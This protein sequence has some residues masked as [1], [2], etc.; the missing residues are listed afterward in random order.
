MP[1][2]PVLTRRVE[3]TPL[4][5]RPDEDTAE[6]LKVVVPKAQSRPPP[7]SQSEDERSPTKVRR[8]RDVSTLATLAR[9]DPRRPLT[10]SQA[11]ATL[12]EIDEDGYKNCRKKTPLQDLQPQSPVPRKKPRRATR[13]KSDTEGEDG[14]NMADESEA[15]DAVTVLGDESPDLDDIDG[16]ECSS[17]EDPSDDDV[18][19]MLDSGQAADVMDRRMPAPLLEEPGGDPLWRGAT[20]WK[21]L[22]LGHQQR[23][24]PGTPDLAVLIETEDFPTEEA[25]AQFGHP[26]GRIPPDPTVGL[27]FDKGH[28]DPLV[29]RAEEDP[30]FD[31][32]VD[33][34]LFLA[35]DLELRRRRYLDVAP[36]W[37][38]M[39]RDEVEFR[40]LEAAVL[41]DLIAKGCPS[42][43]L[44]EAHA[45]PPRAHND[46]PEPTERKG[47]PPDYGPV[48]QGKIKLLRYMKNSYLNKVNSLRRRTACPGVLSKFDELNDA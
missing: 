25:L 26:K 10:Q 14:G 33:G 48:I 31:A 17:I 29:R 1:E 21:W 7:S 39:R 34:F 6:Q 30:E 41:Q 22:Y 28:S 42:S 23:F 24:L 3:R 4:G 13:P 46:V 15:D 43:G 36:V 27:G 38:P 16:E 8:L 44:R 40:I 47:K 32:Y 9:P 37:D 2:A 35:N 45:I 18:Q 5:R 19:E 11:R 12:I 20:E